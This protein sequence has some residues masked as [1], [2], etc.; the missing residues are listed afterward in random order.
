MAPKNNYSEKVDL[1]NKLIATNPKIER[2]GAT[3]PYTSHNGNMFTILYK[4][5]TVGIRLGEKERNE[6]IKKYKTKSPEQYG[7]VLKE[8]VLV[9]DKL[10]ENTKELK[11]YLDLSF[12]YVKT[13]KVKPT[14]KK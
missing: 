1:Y 5:G 12:E 7:V 10:L 8:Y 11:K 13:L 9:P 4:D 2:K 6:F 3:M 14:K